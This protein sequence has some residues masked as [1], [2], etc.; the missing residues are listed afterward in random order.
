MHVLAR[1][2]GTLVDPDVPLIR[3]D[4]LGIVRGDG[5]FETIPVVDGVPRELGPH[6][7][8]LARSARMLDLPEPDLAA[9][10]RVCRVVIGTWQ[11]GRDMAL[12][13]VY[14]RG[15]ESHSDAGPAQYALGFEFPDKVIR[16]RE[17][18]VAAVTLDR[19]V[20]SRAFERAPWLLLSAKMLSYGVN[21]AALREAARR[22]A[23]DAIFV[24]SD[25]YVLECPTCTVV[26]AK[27]RTLRTPPPS[28]GILAG[29]TQAALFRGAERA[30][31]A[32]K[33]EPV[34][35]AELS[36]A[37]AVLLVSSARRVTRVHTLDGVALPDS[38]T[39]HAEL[40]TAYES[41]YLP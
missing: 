36:Q 27:G 35:A 9:W 19:G 26:V 10:E 30:G 28:V 15:P 6:L 31:W 37:D 13:L 12:K 24:T 20:D 41:V 34:T 8:R 32:T 14:T 38:R 5:V 4:D 40:F 29:T 39:L 11:G 25:G 7:E 33:T 3:A 1:I 22:H 23:D 2:D 21:M 17:T 16:D 18:G